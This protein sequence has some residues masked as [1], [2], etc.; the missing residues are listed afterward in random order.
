MNQ[1]TQVASLN[2]LLR[3][4]PRM[5]K[6]TLMTMNYATDKPLIPVFHVGDRLAKARELAGITQTEFG[7]A[8]GASRATVSRW[9]RGLGVKKSTILLYAMRTGVPSEWI[10]T[11]EWCT[12]PDLNREPTDSGSGMLLHFVPRVSKVLVAA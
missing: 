9:E 2:P 1:V 11:G 7:D 12:P 6:V 8:I 3:K 4:L 10:E 5:G